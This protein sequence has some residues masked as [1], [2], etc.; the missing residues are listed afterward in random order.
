MDPANLGRSCF[1]GLERALVNLERLERFL[2]R[3]EWGLPARVRQG[4][5][6]DLE[7]Y[8]AAEDQALAAGRPY[9]SATARQ[10]G[11][12]AR[13]LGLDSEP[14][15]GLFRRM[16]ALPSPDFLGLRALRRLGAGQGAVCKR[17]RQSGGRVRLELLGPGGEVLAG[18]VLN[19]EPDGAR[20]VEMVWGLL[21]H[22]PETG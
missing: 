7:A 19:Q 1:R 21:P 18:A 13:R 2:A 12:L 20:R 4:L 16:A 9:A 11:E 17:L 10:A 5:A 14:W 3:A 8:L 6:A 22:P 15:A